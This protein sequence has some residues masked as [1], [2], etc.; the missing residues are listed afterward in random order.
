MEHDP[1]VLVRLV[2]RLQTP[3]GIARSTALQRD[4]AL[5]P[6]NAVTRAW[7]VARPRRDFSGLT[8]DQLRLD[9]VAAD[10][11]RPRQPVAGVHHRAWKDVLLG[12]D[13]DATTPHDR[14]ADA[15]VLAQREAERQ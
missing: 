11:K 1:L 4:R 9:Q 8:N 12:V 6:A 5:L 3:Q 15:P 13:P 10:R 7:H 14:L 2:G